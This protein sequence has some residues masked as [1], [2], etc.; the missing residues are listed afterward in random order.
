MWNEKIC[1][2]IFLIY[3]SS[4]E[5]VKR[6]CAASAPWSIHENLFQSIPMLAKT[7]NPETK[8]Q[9]EDRKRKNN[10]DRN[11]LREN[12]IMF[13]NILLVLLLLIFPLI[14]KTQNSSFQQK[15]RERKIWML[16]SFYVIRKISPK[17]MTGCWKH[18]NA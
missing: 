6:M 2:R 12:C 13:E 17:V 5:S 4:D 14:K 7:H 1:K 3:F 11:F 9:T 18:W 15:K 16:E 10:D 8:Y